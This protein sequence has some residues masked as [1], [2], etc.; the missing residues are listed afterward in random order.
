MYGHSRLLD[1]SANLRF[2]FTYLNVSALE[3]QSR[4]QRMY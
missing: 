3:N 4:Q 2:L 1:L